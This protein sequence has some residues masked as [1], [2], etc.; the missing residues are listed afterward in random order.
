MRFPRAIPQQA[1]AGCRAQRWDLLWQSQLRSHPE[2]PVMGPGGASMGGQWSP[3]ALFSKPPN[4]WRKTPCS[5]DTSS[6][7]L[8][9][10]QIYLNYK[11]FRNQTLTIDIYTFVCEYEWHRMLLIIT[12]LKVWLQFISQAVLLA[13]RKPRT[14]VWVINM[15]SRLF[16]QAFAPALGTLPACP[17][18]SGYTDKAVQEH[19]SDIHE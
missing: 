8:Q 5:P 9:G 4:S 18:G 13:K 6:S 15:R 14:A 16:K 3:L 10:K 2:M 1:A 7:K 19:T 11:V 12:H 17:P